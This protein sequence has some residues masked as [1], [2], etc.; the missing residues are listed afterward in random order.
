MDVSF[1]MQ[2]I[3][4]EHPAEDPACPQF[5]EY[6]PAEMLPRLDNVT[7]FAWMVYLFS[8]IQVAANTVDTSSD[9]QA[10]YSA[11][12]QTKCF[13]PCSG[14]PWRPP[15]ILHTPFQ[16]RPFKLQAMSHSSTLVLKIFKYGGESPNVEITV[17][18]PHFPVISK[19]VWYNT[20]PTVSDG[21]KSLKTIVYNYMVFRFFLFKFKGAWTFSIQD[22]DFISH[23]P[24]LPVMATET[25]SDVAEMKP[26]T[27]ANPL[28]PHV[29][30]HSLGSTR[31]LIAYQGDCPNCLPSPDSLLH[32][33]DQGTLYVSCLSHQYSV[34]PRH[35]AA[36]EELLQPILN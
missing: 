22:K 34:S 20:F 4:R 18:S 21:F 1:Y 3:K 31:N 33:V 8:C 15:G 36:L 11:H 5:L 17:G 6:T 35:R 10:N 14:D 16:S 12:G 9:L 32:A 13:R 19:Y 2:P 23:P 30:C 27:S 26:R 7:L 24:L 28:A 29:Q 25:G